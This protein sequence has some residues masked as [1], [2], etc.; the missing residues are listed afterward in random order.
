MS[1]IL[2]ALLVDECDHTGRHWVV[3]A[4]PFRSQLIVTFGCW[5]GASRRKV[6]DQ[7][8]A[9]GADGWDL[10]RPWLPRSPRPVPKRILAVVERRLKELVRQQTNSEEESRG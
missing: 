3:T 7:T 1:E 5:G 4:R 2:P 6:L 10:A 8:S 9:W